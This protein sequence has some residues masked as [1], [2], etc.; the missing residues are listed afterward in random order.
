MRLKDQE[1]R[2]CSQCGEITENPGYLFTDKVNFKL[3]IQPVLTNHA[4]PTNRNGGRRLTPEGKAYK[5]QLGWAAKQALGTQPM[6]TCPSVSFIFVYSDHRRRDVDSA[7]KL[8]L[9]ALTGIL[10][11]DDS[12]VQELHLYKR[13]GKV[14]S[15]EVTVTG[16]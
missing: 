1:T 4:Y 12:C 2:Q 11:E 14:S 10:F 8:S 7:A 9:D 16:N 13:F 15:V 3:E 5:D 6:F